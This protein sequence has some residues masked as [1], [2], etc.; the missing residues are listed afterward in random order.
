M[1]KVRLSASVDADLIAAAEAAVARG[2]LESVSAWVNEALRARADHDRRLEA[3]G[4]FVAAYET[5]HGEI[6]AEEM[7]SAA[8][9]ARS[10]AVTRKAIRRPLRRSKSRR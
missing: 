5:E 9:L 7:R 8:R 10:R 3:L 4:A 2:R 6:S 1:N